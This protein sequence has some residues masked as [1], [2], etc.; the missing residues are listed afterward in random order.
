MKELQ[1]TWVWSLGGEDPLEEEMATHSS[2]LAWRIPWTEEPGGLQSRVSQRAGHNWAHTHNFLNDA[3]LMVVSIFISLV[4]YDFK[5]LFYKKKYIYLGC[6][7]S[8]LCGLLT[9]VASHCGAQA[10]CTEAQK[11]QYAES[12]ASKHV[13]SSQTRD[14]TCVPWIGRRILNHWT[15]RDVLSN[16]SSFIYKTLSF[17]ILYT[18]CSYHWAILK[19]RFIVTILVVLQKLLVQS[20]ALLNLGHHCLLLCVIYL[21][22]L[23]PHWTEVFKFEVLQFIRVFYHYFL[24]FN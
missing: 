7:G 11:L 18:V 12:P 14:W 8:S 2:I 13:E 5:L 20:E 15:T 4:T 16:F 24:I 3:S 19:V 22:I 6:S 17:P 21:A 23:A 1:E 10:L 9:S